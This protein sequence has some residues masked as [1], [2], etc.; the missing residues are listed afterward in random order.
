M[1]KLRREVEK[2]EKIIFYNVI[3]NFNPFKFDG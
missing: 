3:Y 1:I 2:N